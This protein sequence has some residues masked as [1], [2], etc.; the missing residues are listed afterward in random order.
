[1]A[2]RL[3]TVSANVSP[4]GRRFAHL[5]SRAPNRN[6]QPFAIYNALGRASHGYTH[7]ISDGK[8]LF[9]PL[10]ATHRNNHKP[11]LANNIARSAPCSPF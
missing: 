8:I 1:M 7:S 5:L 6:A 11:F 4:H 9:N 2:H 3:W 10:T